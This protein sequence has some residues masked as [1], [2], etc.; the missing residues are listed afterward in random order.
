[1][2][3]DDDQCYRAIQSRDARFDGWFVTAVRTTG[4]YCRPS[5]PAITP[6]R[7]NV[8]FFRAAATA[9]AHG[10]RACKRCRPDASPG[11]PEWNARA[12]VVGRAMRLIA[13]GLVDR[14]GVGGLAGRLG[15]SERQVHRLLVAEVGSGPLALARAQRAQTARILIETTTLPITDVAFAAGFQSVRQFNDTVREV[16][17]AT[18]SQLRTAKSPSPTGGPL[19]VRLACREPFDGDALFGFLAARAV[20]GVEAF[21]G[22]TYR[23][24]LRL[25]RGLGVVSITTAGAAVSCSLTLDDVADAQAAVQRTRRLLD[26]DC[27]PA[28]IHDHLAADPL[29]APLVAKRPGLRAPG[30]PDGTELLVRAVLGQ[31]VSVAGA[32]TLAARLVAGHGQPLAEPVGPITHAFPSAATIAGLSPDDFAMPRARGAALI[33]A[34]ARVAAGTLVLDAGSDRADAVASLQS[35]KGIGPWTAGYVAMRA[36]GDPDV[37]LPTDLGV[38]H[39]LAALG[40][41]ASPKAAAALAGAWQPWRSYALHHLWASL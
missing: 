5:C 2:L 3:L 25:S 18:P 12:D 20:P 6:K 11:S 8:E 21:D 13:D 41:D 36:L 35:L 4:I 16:Y 37:F 9:Q 1:M 19:T 26:L 39:A 30:H 27:D 17:A 24:S 14:E 34:C 31:Q 29:L 7:P 33:D 15:Y 10:Y 38:R 23:R 28:S 32:R 22:T 40:A